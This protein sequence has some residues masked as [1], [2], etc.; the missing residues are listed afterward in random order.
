MSNS[1]PPAWKKRWRVQIQGA[2]LA[3]LTLAPFLM[4]GSLQSHTPIGM[5]V[6]FFLIALGMTITFWIS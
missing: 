6:G 4:Y 5:W 2:A 1:K 3:L